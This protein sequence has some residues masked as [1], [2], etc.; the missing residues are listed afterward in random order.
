PQKVDVPVYRLRGGT[1]Q[2]KHVPA[3]IGE[4]LRAATAARAGFPRPRLLLH[5]E[6]GAFI[7]GLSDP[8]ASPRLAVLTVRGRLDLVYA[9]PCDINISLLVGRNCSSSI[10]SKG[11]EHKVPLGLKCVSG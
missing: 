7:D 2:R 11:V 10:E 6:R 9:M 8:E 3:R 5:P 1:I 4:N